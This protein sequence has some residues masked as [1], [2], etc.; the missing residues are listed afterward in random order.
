MT[1]PPTRPAVA[2][3]AAIVASAALYRPLVMWADNAW[4][5]SSPIKLF[6]LG[7]GVFFFGVL[8]LLLPTRLG[9]RPVPTALGVAY[10]LIVLLTWNSIGILTPLIWIGLVIVG[11]IAAH[12]YL[13]DR[14]LRGVAAVTIAVLA[15]APAL[16][17]ALAHIRNSEP[18]P[19]V[20]LATRAPAEPTG[21]VEDVLLVIVDSYP[22]LTI[23]EEWFEH[24][25]SRLRDDLLAEGFEVAEVAWSQHTFTGLA[26]PSMLELQP[27]AE[28]SGSQT[29]PW[30]NRASTYRILRGDS[31]AATT[32]ISAGF[33]YTHIESGWDASS[34]GPVD[35]C[36]EAPWLDELV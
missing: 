12:V 18:Y 22:S 2:L 27:I 7:L 17:V 9:A 32:L 6:G 1:E 15:V 13:S 10:L 11:T 29:K 24:D 36:L 31:L 28:P 30:G 20:E 35:L 4:D 21:L 16:Q 14:A 23:A 34:C 33:E 26:V 3:G 8:L 5:I 19:I 25:T